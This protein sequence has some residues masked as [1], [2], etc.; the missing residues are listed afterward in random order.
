MQKAVS[1]SASPAF[2]PN[3]SLDQGHLQEVLEFTGHR[4]FCKQRALKHDSFFKVT[5]TGRCLWY[6]RHRKQKVMASSC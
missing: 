3:W 4:L 1:P 2:T 5:L 6:F